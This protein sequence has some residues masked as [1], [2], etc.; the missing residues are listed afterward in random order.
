MATYTIKHPDWVYTQSFINLCMY[1][2]HSCE[3]TKFTIL[4]LSIGSKRNGKKKKERI[5]RLL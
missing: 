5:L 3:T 2:G 1:I 4:K